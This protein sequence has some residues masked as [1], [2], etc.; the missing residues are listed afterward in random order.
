MTL[1]DDHSVTTRY[2]AR[3]QRDHAG[4]IIKE[5]VIILEYSVLSTWTQY[6]HKG[7]C[8]REAGVSVPGEGE[9]M[10]EPQAGV[11]LEHRGRSTSQGTWTATRS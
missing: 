2:C 6:D 9:V 7:P 1:K 8:R 10:M 5:F 4:V 11:N 3:G